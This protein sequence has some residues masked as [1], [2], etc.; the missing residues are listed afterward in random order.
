MKM[1]VRT[2]YRHKRTGKVYEYVDDCMVKSDEAWIP[3]VI[4]L[5]RDEAS[6]TV[7]RYVRSRVSFDEDFEQVGQ[8]DAKP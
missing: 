6:N 4:Y 1:R 2:A 8:D 3:G 7:S 5:Y